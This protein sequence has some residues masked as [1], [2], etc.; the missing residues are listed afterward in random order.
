[1]ALKKSINSSKANPIA[2]ILDH[3]KPTGQ[4]LTLVDMTQK[5]KRGRAPGKRSSEAHVITSVILERELKLEA[6]DKARRAGIDLS[7]VLNHLL[8]HWVNNR[9]DIST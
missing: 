9:I 1:M 5:P 3:P 2:A 6:Q 8:T 7:D 4:V